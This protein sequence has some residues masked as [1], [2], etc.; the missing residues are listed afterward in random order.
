MPLKQ[1]Q[2][3]YPDAAAWAFGD[4][5]ELANELAALVINGRKTAS[6]GSLTAFQTEEESPAIGGYSIILNGERQPV[7]VI[8][9]V[10]LRLIRFCDVSEQLARK[11][12]EGDLSLHYWRQAH[13]AFFTRAGYFAEEME[14]VMEEF[15]L[16]EVVE[17]SA[18]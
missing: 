3:K 12:G 7:C 17:Q 5:P 1:L 4:S 6:C 11:E 16:V 14:L 13:Q 2:E 9:T 8:R 15:E 18:A 10:A